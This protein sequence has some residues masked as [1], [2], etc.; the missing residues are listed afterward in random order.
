MRE[1]AH[2]NDA[3]P[4]RAISFLSKIFGFVMGG[5]VLHVHLKLLD[6]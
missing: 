4:F 6:P 3:L 1:A 2:A 5:R